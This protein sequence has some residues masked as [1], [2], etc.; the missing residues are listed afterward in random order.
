M[1]NC[2]NNTFYYQFYNFENV[3]VFS[4]YVIVR[5]IFVDNL[6]QFFLKATLFQNFYLVFEILLIPKKEPKLWEIVLRTYSFEMIIILLLEGM[7]L[8][9]IKNKFS[10][11]N[12]FYKYLTQNKRK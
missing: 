7:Q 6:R 10:E 12:L 4:F 11:F 3:R 5:R 8:P 2:R 9:K 1:E